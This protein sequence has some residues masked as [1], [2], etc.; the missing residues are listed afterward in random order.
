MGRS[1]LFQNPNGYQEFSK[2]EYLLRHNRARKLM[3]EQGIDVL[4]VS[5]QTNCRY[6]T[7]FKGR[8]INRPAFF[9][10]PMDEEPVLIASADLGARDA[11]MRTWVKEIVEYPL[12]VT[13]EP[14]RSA[15][16]RLKKK[17][18]R[19]GMEIDDSVFGGFRPALSH[20]GFKN[21]TTELAG[22]ESCNASPLIWQLRMVKTKAE[23]ACIEMASRIQRNSYARVFASI[24]EG[25]TEEEIGRLLLKFMIDEG[26]DIPDI[27]RQGPSAML[28]INTSRL[29]GE[30]NIASKRRLKRGDLL[31][32]DTGAIFR[33]YY[34][35]FACSGVLGNPSEEQKEIRKRAVEKVSLALGKLKSGIKG[36]EID[37][38]W[39]GVGLD[40]VEAPFRGMVGK[41]IHQE[42]EICSGMTLCL[43]EVITA[44]NGETAHFEEVVLITDSGYENLS[45]A[46]KELLIVQPE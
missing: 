30:P 4:V 25:M 41:G 21:L 12:P 44:P 6:F 7:G 42:L 31:R 1:E 8:T 22:H 43:E 5:D 33:G 27:G 9:V 18:R 11:R 45:H 16:N 10:L 17:P 28:I 35:D 19:I 36:K 3:E 37:S 14:I 24:R 20:A 38:H 34:T 15:I 32:I 2:E 46:E 13:Y 29:P 23:V 39:H 26:A 40:Y